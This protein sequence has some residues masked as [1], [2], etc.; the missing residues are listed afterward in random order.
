MVDEYQPQQTPVGL[1][2]ISSQAVAQ[3]AIYTF[4]LGV[5]RFCGHLLP[6]QVELGV[7]GLPHPLLAGM[8]PETSLTGM[9]LV[10]IGQEKE[11]QEDLQAEEGKG[12]G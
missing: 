4:Y 8:T 3:V 10:I 6:G 1:L 11:E 12:Q 7:T 5:A 9:A 2:W